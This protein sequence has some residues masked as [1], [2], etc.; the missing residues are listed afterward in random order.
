VEQLP[1]P[2]VSVTPAQPAARADHEVN[3]RGRASLSGRLARIASRAPLALNAGLIRDPRARTCAAVYAWGRVPLWPR[4]PPF[5]LEL[6]NPYV[7]TLY[8]NVESHRRMRPVLRQILLSDRCAGIVC[9]SAACQKTLAVELGADVA[10]KSAIVAPHVSRGAV[11]HPGEGAGPLRLVCV[12]TQFWLKG[13]RELCAATA[14]LAR[15]GVDINLT[16]VTNVPSEIRARHAGDPITFVAPT[17][18]E[19]VLGSIL[20]AADV[21]VLPTVQES[22]GLAALEAIACGLPVVA[23]GIY[24]LPELVEDGVTGYLLDDPLGLWRS[25]GTA[26]P[27]LWAR[28]DI[29]ALAR[30]RPFP[31]LQAQLESTL[32]ELANDRGRVRAMSAATRERFERRFS[33]ERRAAD[34]TQALES[35]LGLNRGASAT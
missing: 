7:L 5:I 31:A 13:G 8:H 24:A 4:E 9:I 30:D 2:F 33:P 18:R 12:G 6:D 11:A 21:F 3:A 20:P 29:D 15:G 22:Y 23:T 28:R 1:A 34:F 19:R 17:D 32:S 25:D 14:A 10:A 26:E 35:M 16:M 27:A